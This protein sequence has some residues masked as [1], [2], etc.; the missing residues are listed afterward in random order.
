[1]KLTKNIDKKNEY[2]KITNV[3]LTQEGAMGDAK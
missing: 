3:N 1:M 2:A